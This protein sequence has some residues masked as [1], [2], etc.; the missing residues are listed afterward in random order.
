MKSR[1]YSLIISSLILYSVESNAEH[2]LN[3]SNPVIVKPERWQPKTLL[4]FG[5]S[6]SDSNG[7][8]F[9]SSEDAP[10]TF[11]LLRSLKGDINPQTGEPPVDLSQ[12]FSRASSIRNIEATFDLYRTEL[13]AE[14]RERSFLRRLMTGLEERVINKLEDLITSLVDSL[15][16]I[17]DRV[18]NHLLGLIEHTHYF[19]RKI[20]HSY[21]AQLITPIKTITKLLGNKLQALSELVKDDLVSEIPELAEDTLLATTRRFAGQIPLVPDSQHYEKGK[22]TTGKAMDLMWPEVLV[23]MMSFPEENKV[24]LD[25]RAMAGSWILCTESKLGRPGAFLRSVGGMLDAVVTAF[26]GS[27]LPPCEGLIVQSYLNERRN[28]VAET[29]VAEVDIPLRLMPQDALVIFFNGGNDFLNNWDDPDDIAQEQA[30]DI[31]NVL[32]AGAQRVIVFLLPDITA[33]PRFLNSPMRSELH[34]KWLKYNASLSMRINLLREAFPENHGY[35]VMKIDGEE[36][37]S[38][39][40]KDPQWDFVH[41]ILDIPIPGMDDAEAVE[42]ERNAFI[43]EKRREAE[44]QKNFVSQELLNNAAFDDNWQPTGERFSQVTPL[45]TAFYSDSVH[46]SAEAHYAIAEETCVMISERFNI[47]CDT[48]NYPK[49]QAIKE[50]LKRKP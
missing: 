35:R 18:D 48:G 1:L 12:F 10:S 5:D 16:S 50:A 28:A 39:L 9:H 19:I 36:V 11:N 27:L 15:K 8:D 17:E 21:L 6:L 41:P 14:K 3:I 24:Q 7:D 47:P 22:W 44:E 45:K 20:E 4:I 29:G 25:N 2:M 43:T 46:P 30:Q 33:A 49:N 38:T 32:Q 23:K 31:Y 40:R 37:F 26:Q 13:Q 34:E 42:I